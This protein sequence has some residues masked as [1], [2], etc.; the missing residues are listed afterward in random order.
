MWS[1]NAKALA[2]DGFVK[3]HP[4]CHYSS[5]WSNM[6]TKWKLITQKYEK[7]SKDQ[8]AY[9]T[10]LI[11]TWKHIQMRMK[12]N[13][14]NKSMKKDQKIKWHILIQFKWHM[15]WY[16]IE[17]RHWAYKSMKKYFSLRYV[18]KKYRVT[19]NIDKKVLW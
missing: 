11:D 12:L 7:R 2:F 16:P 1:Q 15:K 19:K 17:D 6:L 3:T 9:L 13:C 5:V 10:Q 4:S 14:T 18:T 8:L